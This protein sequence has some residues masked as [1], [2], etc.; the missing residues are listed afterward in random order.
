MAG[1]GMN[2]GVGLGVIGVKIFGFS[3][4]RG[5]AGEGGSVSLVPPPA[6]LLLASS[7]ATIVPMIVATAA[8]TSR[9]I[10]HVGCAILS[11]IRDF[12]FEVETLNQY[13]SSK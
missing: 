7:T 3:D 6:F 13:A 12:S 1:S 5:C 8:K 4:G 11:L 9:K 2:E 10:S